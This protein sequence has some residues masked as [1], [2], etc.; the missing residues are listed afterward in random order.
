MT[1]MTVPADVSPKTDSEWDDSRIMSSLA[2][3]QEMHAQLRHLRDTFPRLVDPMLVQPSSPE[4]LYTTFS[5]T[6]GTTTTDVKNFTRLINDARSQ[7][8][9]KR[10]KESRA[11]N[12]GS[13]IGWD[14][15][16]H[17]DWLEVH[18]G[19]SP[20][21]ITMGDTGDTRQEGDSHTV[22]GLRA[23]LEKFQSNHPGIQ[24]LLDE[25]NKCFKMT[26]PPPL[27]IHFEIFSK[28]A[29]G[30]PSKFDIICIEKSTSETSIMRSINA[31]PKP[32]DPNQVLVS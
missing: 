25:D 11:D 30:S 16:E 29:L 19:D 3:L 17:E 22:V 18:G 13:I 5:S 28:P 14:P 10:A 15:T 31:R 6:V 12:S 2:R 24:T 8:I 26:L 27:N 9:L 4:S 32:N 20:G 23:A 1:T 21:A 7:D